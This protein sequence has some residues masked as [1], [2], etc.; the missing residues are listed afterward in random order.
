MKH[1]I[2]E[3]EKYVASIMD[4]PAIICDDVIE[5]YDEE[6]KTIPK[7]FNGKNITCKTQNFYILL[8][9]LL[10]TITLLIAIS[11]YCYLIKYQAKQK[12]KHLIP[13]RDTKLKQINI[14]NIN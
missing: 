2:C 6:I 9:F 10:I 5:S 7:N 12:Q 4:D 3:N 14:D 11:T 13:F 1:E 8:A